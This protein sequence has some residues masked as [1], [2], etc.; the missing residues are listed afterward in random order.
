MY[1]YDG[2]RFQRFDSRDGLPSNG[3]YALLPTPEGL[4]V[5]TAEGLVRLDHGRATNEGVSLVAAE[6]TNAL[7]T[8]P[9]G[10]LW[11]ATD[12][13][14]FHQVGT[15]L[16]L[17][18]GWPGGSSN[19]VWIDKDGFV[20]ASRGLGVVTRDRAGRW[21]S[22]EQEL[23]LGRA[24][25]RSIVRTADHTVWLRSAEDTWE[26]DRTVTT[27]T[28]V[29]SQL[30][31][32]GET[33][34]MF[35]D[36]DGLLWAATRRGLAHRTAPGHWELLGSD[37]GLPARSVLTA[38]E[39]REGSLWIAA[40][41]LYQLLGRGLWR[42]YTASHGF[43]A[44]SAW[45]VMRDNTG[46]L[47]VGTNRGL[48][49]AHGDRW[50]TVSG[51][52]PY[53]LLTVVDAGA[54]LYAAGNAPGV[55]VIDRATQTLMAVI[56]D[57]VLGTDG[58]ISM[59]YDKD[60]LW[61]ATANLGLVRMTTHAGRHTWRREEITGGDAREHFHQVMF[62]RGGRLWAAG[63]QGL[64]VL[65]GGRWQ[66]FMP[67]DGLASKHVQY[68]AERRSGELCVAYS[69]PY[70]VTC[71][72]PGGG[73][74]AIK[75][76]HL[77]HITTLVGLTSDKIYLLG[78]DQA[79]RLYAG[80]GNGL[81][82][83]GDTTIEHF[84]TA[85]G[86]VGDDCAARAFWS[87]PTGDVMIGTTR[88]LAR[89]S[90][91]RY[92]GPLQPIAPVVLE[93]KFD[94][95]RQRLTG[96]L[97]APASGTADVTLRFAT[98][99]FANRTRLEQQTRLL[100]MEHDFRTASGDEARYAQLP[101]GDYTFEIR[102]RFPPGEYGPVTRVALSIR[103][104]WWQTTLIRVL[105]VLVLLAIIARLIAWRARVISRRGAA[106]IIARSQASFR[107]LIEESPDAVFVHRDGLLVYA[108][109]R[110][111]TYLGYA[112]AELV[113]MTL[114][115]LV[116]PEERAGFSQDS[117]KLMTTG[118]S[119]AVR[120]VRMLRKDGSVIF[121]EISALEVEFAGSPAQLSIARDCTDRKGLEAR[122]MASDR[123]A[124]VGT[125]AAGIAHE[126]NNPLAYLKANLEVISDELEHASASVSL[127]SAVVDALDGATRVQDIIKGVRTFSR[128]EDEQRQPI[129][130]RR[131]VQLALRMTA[132]ELRHRCRV[133]ESYGP[134][135]KV[136]GS[137]SRLGQVF[138]NLL[139]NAAQAMPTGAIDTSE[140]RITTSTDPRG[141][142]VIEIRD[143]GCGMAPD[144]VKRAFEPFFTTKD[145][146]KGTG[147]GLS[148]CHG[149]IH[150]LGGTIVAESR[151]GVGTM[152]R[153]TLPA[154]A[155][156]PERMP[157]TRIEALA[158][159]RLTVLVIDDDVKL[160]ASIGRTLKK[161]HEVSLA[162]SPT[163]ALALLEQ[164]QRFDVIL[165]DLMMPEI[166]GMELHD[167]LEA[168]IPEQAR[169]ML[170]MT[171]GTFTEEAAKFLE[172]LSTRW[173]EK[174]FETAEL[175]RRIH[176]IA[177]A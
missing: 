168:R 48:L 2:A 145:V 39:D 7:T 81:D 157:S 102:S 91:R 125:L 149:I 57:A 108:N 104:A 94:D 161:E 123:M 174:P 35:V 86:L 45:T 79:G 99:A 131:A 113:G 89:F 165:C 54:V 52:E 69:E 169:Q 78:E 160:L 175:R 164:G 119:P 121:V 84:S 72:R 115:A 110:T 43:P 136:L 130:I 148:I 140:I 29:S 60:T 106:R 96:R 63:W 137:E 166:T 133:V 147:L 59:A 127:R 151:L 112:N 14:L 32:V 98:P 8:G 80:M 65:D 117:Q 51:T 50:A 28:D 37:Q 21:T 156:T 71:F 142:A 30:P 87:D 92:Q 141:D 41:E 159:S 36:H 93:V 90:A 83:I 40:G 15:Q 85:T 18:A 176:A 82:I 162:S 139:V 53:Q 111:S 118:R 88:G 33:S 122:L 105:A 12:S 62:D 42:G 68:L 134:V 152:L 22:R 77:R 150:S 153:I 13:G 158:A 27:C 19:A 49:Y 167:T 101:H 5:G 128:V 126:I 114:A 73:A 146:G 120:E 132:A 107:A 74:S 38:F 95:A 138:M 55:M 31:D 154:A 61:L 124:S 1:S 46:L 66:R 17:A 100:P 44:D 25:I 10:T 64:A 163:D 20:I 11:V 97:E 177:R 26:C 103:P 144:V 4:W 58:I 56:T 171:G 6:A 9:D 3:I 172:R 173:L 109:A 24:R 135:P 16:A 23:G 116:S 129:E 34:D 170:F 75:L 155:P 143:S 76:E 70:G 67:A 47:W